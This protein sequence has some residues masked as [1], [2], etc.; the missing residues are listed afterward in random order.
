MQNMTIGFI[1]GGNMGQSIISGLLASGYDP[2]LIWVSN[3][4]QEKL[5]DLR[6]RFAVH[7]TQDNQTVVRHANVLVLAIKPQAAQAVIA[8]LAPAIQAR[9]PLVLSVMAGIRIATLEQWLGE[10]IAVVRCMPNLPALIRAGASGLYANALVSTE[11]K[12]QAE[13]I[14]RAVGIT[15]WLAKEEQLDTVTALS[16]CGPAYFFRVM[17]VIEDAG[18]ALG[19]PP[20]EAHLLTLQTALGAVRVALESKEDLATLRRRV[21]APKGSTE[22]A[23]QVLE[24]GDIAGL[25]AQALQAAKQRAE[26]IADDYTAR[27]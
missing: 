1:G 17:E 11:Q 18:V 12:N 15:T 2:A 21:A 26:E 24:A 27:T 22:R 7:T 5:A 8:T 4:T 25:F 6:A 13:S 16:G 14:M 3:P 9:K 20:E 10:G 19:L 23:L